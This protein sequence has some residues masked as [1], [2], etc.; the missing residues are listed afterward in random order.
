MNRNTII[1]IV[2]IV[3]LGVLGY[4]TFSTTGRI[5]PEG[6]NAPAPTPS[7]EPAKPAD[8]VTPGNSP[9]R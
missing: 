8:P 1:A 4:A 5:P 2:V 3:Q 9:V 7:S 6:A